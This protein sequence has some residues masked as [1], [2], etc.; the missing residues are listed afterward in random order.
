MANEVLD[1]ANEI[2]ATDLKMVFDHSEFR[3][4]FR[5]R[6]YFLLDKDNY[7]IIKIS[8][9]KIPF[10]G[11]GKRFLDLFNTLTEKGGNSLVSG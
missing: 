2:G 10:W 1:F 8:R 3:G 4:L 11:L 5:Q 6:N 9:I 7:L